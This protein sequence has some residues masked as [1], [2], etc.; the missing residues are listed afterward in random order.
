ML[1]RFS[2]GPDLDNREK[3]V[4]VNPAEVMSVEKSRRSNDWALITVRGGK[5]YL[6]V[7]TVEAVME[8]LNSVEYVEILKHATMGKDK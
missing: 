2:Q 6:V 5:E 8:K 1:V 4:A 7:G 3:T